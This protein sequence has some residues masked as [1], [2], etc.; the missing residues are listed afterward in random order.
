MLCLLGTAWVAYTVMS[1]AGL[2]VHTWRPWSSEDE[3]FECSIL[4][5]DSHF[6]FGITQCIKYL[7]PNLSLFIIP[8]F[9]NFNLIAALSCSDLLKVCIKSSLTSGFAYH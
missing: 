4:L 9:A 3:D 1:Q 8:F 2:E 5:I 7:L 6:Q